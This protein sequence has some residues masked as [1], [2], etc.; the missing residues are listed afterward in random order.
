M[1]GI[2][3]RLHIGT[4]G[5]NAH[6]N[7]HLAFLRFQRFLENMREILRRVDDAREK[8]DEEYI[9]DRH[10]ILSLVD[11]V[12]DE[13]SRLAFNASVLAPAAGE[14]IFQSMDVHKEFAQNRFLKSSAGTPD[15]L[16]PSDPEADPEVQ[17]LQAVLEWLEGPPLRG[18][19]LLLDFL[20]DTADAV[21]Q[22]CRKDELLRAE[23]SPA[24]HVDLKG[25]GPLEIVDFSDAAPDESSAASIENLQ[26]RPFSLLVLGLIDEGIPGSC[27]G[28]EADATRWMLFDRETMSLRIHRNN[29]VV[30]LEAALYGKAASDFVFLYSQSPEDMQTLCPEDVRVEKTGRGSMAWIYDAPPERLEKLLVQMGSVLLRRP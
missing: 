5:R 12:L 8:L 23:G 22:L 7:L 24:K 4:S 18:Q 21:M 2:L 13:C 27:P 6:R 11:S 26:C 9:F 15:G 28:N 17:F 29:R 19:P 10:Y 1:A 30:H 3:E 20:R 16:S 25:C 14:R